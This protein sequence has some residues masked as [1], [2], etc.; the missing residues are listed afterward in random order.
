M[1][2]T[3]RPCV[4]VIMPTHDGADLIART[5]AC[6]STQTLQNFEAV[7]VDDCSVDNTR[8]LIRAHGDSR[9]HLIPLPKN[10]GP[11][12]ARNIAVSHA[13]GRYIAGLDQDDLCHAE[14]LSRQLAHLDAH[15][16]IALLGTAVDILEEDGICSSTA[17]PATTPTLIDWL[18]GIENPLVWSTVMLRR[19]VAEQLNP[20]MRPERIYAEDFDLYHRVRPFGKLARLDMP[21]VTYRRHG[22]GISRRFVERMQQSATDVLADR[23]RNVLADRASSVARLIVDHMMEGLPVPDRVTLEKLGQALSSIQHNFLI[24]HEPDAE[25][26]RLIRWETAL[27]WRRVGRIALREGTLCVADILA[28]R[29]DHL[30]LGYA[31]MHELLLSNAIGVARRH[32]RN[33]PRRDS[34]SKSAD[35]PSGSSSSLSASHSTA[36]ESEGAV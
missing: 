12:E 13:R 34:G 32:R 19:E 17:V 3:A 22:A 23:H 14:R 10:V 25:S 27:R 15:P 18:T 4:S 21:L 31:G 2:K 7:I 1:M 36:D 5:L 26:L 29:P 6:L 9:F 16:D 33:R 35:G 28:V 24:S 20:F 11:V 8:E 30:G